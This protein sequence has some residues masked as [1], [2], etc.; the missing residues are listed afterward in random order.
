MSSTNSRKRNCIDIRKTS[1][2]D[3]GDYYNNDDNEQTKKIKKSKICDNNEKTTI[4]SSS[5]SKPSKTNSNKMK[6]KKK[7]STVKE[8]IFHCIRILKKPSSQQAIIKTMKQ[9]FEYDNINAIKKAL[10]ASVATKD[11]VQ[12]KASFWISGEQ[13]PEHP[14]EAEVFIEEVQLGNK[15]DSIVER[16]SEI[17]IDYDLYL[18]SSSSCNSI[19]NN[20]VAFRS[21]THVEK[22]KKFKFHVGG[23]EVIKGMDAGVLGMKVGGKRRV[24]VPW[25]LGYGKRGS[26]PDI[27]P[28]ADLIFE[29]HLKSMK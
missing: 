8:K 18:S 19:S 29:I 10:K 14:Q 1:I 5:C 25:K 28:E 6:S 17:V 22:G 3:D 11:L 12:L 26:K 27:P 24:S 2:N 15:S 23:G 7:A 20:E 16:G 9:E 21:G 4:N 13:I